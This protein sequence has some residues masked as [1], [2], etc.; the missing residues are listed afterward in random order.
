MTNRDRVAKAMEIMGREQFHFI[1][2]AMKA[3][4]CA[5]QR[6]AVRG[7]LT[8]LPSWARSAMENRYFV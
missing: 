4:R 8:D 2:R 5:K 7:W 6:R 1:V 3:C